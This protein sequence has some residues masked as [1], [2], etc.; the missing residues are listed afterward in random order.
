[1]GERDARFP[2]PLAQRAQ[3]RR[4]RGDLVGGLDH[5]ARREAERIRLV[6]ELRERLDVGHVRVVAHDVPRAVRDRADD[7]DPAAV[8]GERQHAVVLEQHDRL[9]HEPG[10]ER[11]LLRVEL[12][13]HRGGRRV[14]VGPLEQP[15]AELEP[16]VAL[17]REVDERLVDPPV[18]D[19]RDQRPREPGRRRELAVEARAQRHRRGGA[20]VA[21][22]PVLADEHLDR[23]VVGGDDP[24]EAPLVAKDVREQLVRRVAREPVDVAVG[25]HH[26]REPGDADGRLERQQLLVAHLA[27]PEVGRRLV[28]PALGEPV[29]DE[30]LAGRDDAGGHVVALHPA[31]V[32][33]A[34]L[35]REVGVLAIRL[36]DAAPARVAGGVEDRREREPAADREHAPADRGRDRLDE[37][38]VEG[39]RRADRLLERRRPAGE[40]AVERLLVEDRGDP[41]ARLLD[42]VALDRVAGLGG[43][44]RIEVGRAR[45]PA[46]LAHARPRAARGSAP[47]RARSR[48]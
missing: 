11:V 27:R 2:E 32:G 8:T 45:D 21:R 22:Q 34:E 13:E 7:R 25:G 28:E 15:E 16:Q 20:Q 41:E 36:L 30:V 31:D 35:G 9:A 44:R 18:R 26:A 17:D 33:D 42:E 29:A 12:V 38:G 47:G 37:L 10:G 1:M 46:D 14:D 5:V 23:R 48:S 19:R 4:P 3:D 6:A 43:A 39:R 24:V 40:Q